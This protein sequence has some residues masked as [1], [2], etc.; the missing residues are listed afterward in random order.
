M[1]ERLCLCS[2]CERARFRSWERRCKALAASVEIEPVGGG[3]ALHK[4]LDDSATR[5]RTRLCGDVLRRL[6]GAHPEGMTSQ[7]VC[8][9]AAIYQ[10]CF[11]E[12][13]GEFAELAAEETRSMRLNP[14]ERRCPRKGA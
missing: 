11:E 2:T 6:D 13:A 5:R 14:D 12:A 10:W 3:P 4:I 1:R 7:I 9:L 8:A